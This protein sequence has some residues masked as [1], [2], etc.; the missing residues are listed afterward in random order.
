MIDQIRDLQ[1]KRPFE[2]FYIELDSGRV[3]QVD[4]PLEI[5]TNINGHGTIGVLHDN[6]CF[7][8]VAVPHVAAVGLAMHPKV[9][10]DLRKRKEMVRKIFEKEEK[11]DVP[12]SE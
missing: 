9:L 3:I 4:D 8:V 12:R 1:K 2:S 7:D 10:D 11:S 6:G 5:T